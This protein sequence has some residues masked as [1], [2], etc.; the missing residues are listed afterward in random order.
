LRAE[1]ERRERYNGIVATDGA[2]G[3]GERIGC[4]EHGWKKLVGAGSRG[5]GDYCGQ[6]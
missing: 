3:G 5:K 6:S 2:G 1:G 4:A